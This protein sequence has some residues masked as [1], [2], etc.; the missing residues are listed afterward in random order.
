MAHRV[1]LTQYRSKLRQAQAKRK[2][3]I[4][5][6]NREIR[7]YNQNVRTA[8]NKH[9]QG[10]SRHNAKV[11]THNARVRSNRERLRRELNKLAQATSQPRY[12]NF[13]ASVSSVQ[14]SYAQ[15]EANAAT[16]QYNDRFSEV[17][18][19]SEREAANSASVMNALLG[20]PEG[21]KEQ[22]DIFSSKIDH[23]LSAISRDLLDRWHGALFSLNPRNPD[24]A[25]HFCA[26][27]R[28]LLIR[29]IKSRAPDEVVLTEMPGC[30]KTRDGKPTWRAKVG[31]FLWRSQLTDDTLEE[32]AEQDIDNVM[33]LFKECNDGTHG[34]PGHF[35]IHQ[36]VA[37]KKR[38][39][40]AIAFLWSIIPDELRQN[41]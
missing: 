41:A 33:Q 31:Y 11:R 27:S 20:N 21:V 25:R 7:A 1:S 36:L 37:I 38:V 15:L 23:I 17:L 29:I 24:A 32:F 34:S 28:E 5:K 9:N 30:Q 19:L 26:S 6:I 12:T 22:D 39:E 13:R 14:R 16:S 4:D 3:A 35:T 8:V 40:D 18:D 2:H 10:V